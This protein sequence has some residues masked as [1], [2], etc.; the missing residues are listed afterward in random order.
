MKK[1]SAGN[2]ILWLIL[3]GPV[4]LLVAIVAVLLLR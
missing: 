4:I 3:A 2:S 1:P